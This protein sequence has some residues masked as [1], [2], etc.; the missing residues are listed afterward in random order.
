[1]NGGVSTSCSNYAKFYASSM[2]V[3]EDGL[4]SGHTS[5]TENNNQNNILN[6]QTAGIHHTPLGGGISMLMDMKRVSTNNSINSMNNTTI[7]T[8][9]GIGISGSV[10]GGSVVNDKRNTSMS[11]NL[12]HDSYMR[13]NES[14]INGFLDES[15]REA[16]RAK[17][18]VRDTREREIIGQ[19]PNAISNNKV[20]KNIDPDLDSLYSISKYNWLTSRV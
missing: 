9:D 14:P 19:S 2:P 6:Q 13:K 8:T 18:E 10:S 3:L 7:S 11:P 5:D 12:L 20:F 17:P 4:S 1:M 16:V 15:V